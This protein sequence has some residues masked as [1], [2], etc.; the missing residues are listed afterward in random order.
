MRRGWSQ[1]PIG[2]VLLPVQADGQ[3]TVPTFP[4]F[5]QAFYPPSHFCLHLCIS[6]SPQLL[7]TALYTCQYFILSAASSI[8]LPVHFC[9]LHLFLHQSVCLS[10]VHDFTHALSVYQPLSPAAN[11]TSLHPALSRVR[12]SSHPHNQVLQHPQNLQSIPCLL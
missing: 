6:A 11:S 4:S 2:H 1:Q 3:A 7:P 10:N 12:F 8:D 9:L 5:S